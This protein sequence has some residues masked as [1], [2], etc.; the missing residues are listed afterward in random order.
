MPAEMMGVTV[1]TTISLVFS[2]MGE[3]LVKFIPLMFLMRVVYKY[4]SNRKLAVVVSSVIIL[5]CF[6][7][8]HYSP[9]YMTLTSV[10]L[11][12]GLGSIFEVY[13]YL[14]TKNIMVPYISHLLTDLTSF[15]I[16]LIASM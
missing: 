6:G 7:L 11:L 14:K 1:E 13:G 16:I 9:P 4:T 15:I 5:I 10:L 3:E 12:Q 8:M 2:M